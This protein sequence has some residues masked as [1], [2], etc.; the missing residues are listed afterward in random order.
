[1][2]THNECECPW[3]KKRGML[4]GIQVEFYLFENPN[5]PMIL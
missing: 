1:M 3:Y 2:K 4:H 5:K